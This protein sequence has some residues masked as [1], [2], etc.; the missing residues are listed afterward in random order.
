ML[1][2][3]ERQLD[4]RTFP[5]RTYPPPWRPV[6]NVTVDIWFQAI[7]L[8]LGAGL[9]GLAGS[10]PAGG[11]GSWRPAPEL[12]FGEACRRE[13]G[14]PPHPSSSCSCGH[15]P[16]AVLAPNATSDDMVG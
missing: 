7:T 1:A 12:R 9:G 16:A 5:D 14:G 8:A 13:A 2:A 4:R 11:S 3:P 10:G 6:H 15:A